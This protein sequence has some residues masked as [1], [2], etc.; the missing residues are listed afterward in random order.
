MR[1]LPFSH[2]WSLKSRP[3]T[4]FQ[5][6]DA[7]FGMAV[8]FPGPIDE[9]RVDFKHLA[10]AGT[11]RETLKLFNVMDKEEEVLV[12]LACRLFPS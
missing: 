9:M 1:D 5:R 4:F 7:P 12:P 6:P 3:T 10:I 8:A 11:V 2:F